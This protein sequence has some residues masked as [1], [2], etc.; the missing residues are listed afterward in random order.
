MP[1][2]I[3]RPLSPG[4]SFEITSHHRGLPNRVAIY[5]SRTNFTRIG[6]CIA[7]V[8]DHLVMTGRRR[9]TVDL[10]S[11]NPGIIRQVQ[12]RINL[13][14][15][16]EVMIPIELHRRGNRV[17]AI[18]IVDNHMTFE[19]MIVTPEPPGGVSGNIIPNLIGDDHGRTQ[20]ITSLI[21]GLLVD[22]PVGGILGAVISS[23][24]MAATIL[25]FRG[26][27]I[28][29]AYRLGFWHVIFFQPPQRQNPQTAVNSST[30]ARADRDNVI[31]AYNEGYTRGTLVREH[32]LHRIWQQI[33]QTRSQYD[34][35]TAQLIT[36]LNQ[37][38]FLRAR[39]TAVTTALRQQ[40]PYNSDR[41][42]RLIPTP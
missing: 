41:L 31:A 22:M 11:S 34:P 15:G 3:R 2:P 20:M 5:V 33:Y 8:I 30:S 35:T 42:N 39:Q 4:V 38:H 26:N 12:Q 10:I 18:T 9:R 40:Y 1:D 24:Q 27:H 23:I 32:F 28:P 13:T 19:P 7:A 25:E 16:Q 17:F 21:Q 29:N 37:S 14:A 36:E 6:A